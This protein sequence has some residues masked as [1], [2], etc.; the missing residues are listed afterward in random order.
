MEARHC[1]EGSRCG[2]QRQNSKRIPAVLHALRGARR[3][4]MA[5]ASCRCDFA[6][7]ARAGHRPRGAGPT[8]PS[9]P[10]TAP[11]GPSPAS[12]NAR[13]WDTWQVQEAGEGRGGPRTWTRERPRM[14]MHD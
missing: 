3:E 7:Q 11:Q 4:E 6:L 9:R 5:W 1:G 12:R 14:L 8:A 10:L 2:R 13:S